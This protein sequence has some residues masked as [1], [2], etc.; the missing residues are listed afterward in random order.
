MQEN[1]NDWRKPYN[2]HHATQILTYK[3]VRNACGVDLLRVRAQPW[4]AMRGWYISHCIVYSCKKV[5]SIIIIVIILTMA[6]GQPPPP[7]PMMR[8]LSLSLTHRPISVTPI[9][10]DEAENIPI[11]S[12]ILF[13]QHTHQWCIRRACVHNTLQL[14]HCQPGKI[15][16][17]IEKDISIIM[18]ICSPFK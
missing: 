7:P 13:L 2:R 8:G 16:I 5:Y 10:I 6:N 9:P 18:H 11:V 4:Q 15:I 12:N 14:D 3:N 17:F 1:Q